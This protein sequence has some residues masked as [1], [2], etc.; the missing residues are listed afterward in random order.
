[1]K[2]TP[3]E[4]RLSA[5]MD[6]ET[7]REEKEELERLI[8]SDPETR[9]VYEML[10]HG[11]DVG[12][13]A[14]DEVLKE[15]VPLALV[16]AIKSAQPPKVR[17]TPRFVPPSLKLA[18][19]G[20][21]ALAAALILFFVGGGIGYFYGTAPGGQPAA[22]TAQAPAHN[23]TDDI[24][25]S[26]RIYAH[27]P[28][29]LAELPATQVVEITQW[30][31][32]S[33]GVKFNVPDLTSVGLSFQGARLLVAA[34]KPTGQLIYKN[35]DGDVIAVCFLKDN[36]TEDNSEL[37]EVIKDDVGVVS[38]HRNGTAYAVVGPSADAT[39]DDIAGRVSTS[40]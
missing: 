33:V 21:Q 16:R 6:G 24:A 23:W 3:L 4:A 15:P 12:R 22:Q 17:E 13:R 39:L 8:S 26:H 5:Y 19:S 40:I 35:A 10:R 34:G 14:F 31:T 30:L 2:K 27:Q 25:A 11:S 20:R 9:R 38:W 18:P 29:H 7:S 36:G 1:M 28:K 32:G 37:N